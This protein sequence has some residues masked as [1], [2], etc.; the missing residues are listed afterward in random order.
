M[1]VASTYFDTPIRPGLV[2]RALS[3]GE[4]YFQTALLLCAGIA[5]GPLRL[6]STIVEWMQSKP[7]TDTAVQPRSFG[8]T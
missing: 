3:L 2:A 5:L 4:W 6:S 7:S 1:G 8:S